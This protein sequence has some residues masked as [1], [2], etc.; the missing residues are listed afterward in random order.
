[1]RA[2]SRL[3]LGF[4][5]IIMC[6]LVLASCGGDDGLGDSS[7]VI[8]MDDDNTKAALDDGYTYRLPV[9]FHVLYNDADN[10]NQ[11]IPASRLQQLLSYVN[12]IYRGGIFGDSKTVGVTFVAA[13]YDE[14]GNKLSTPGVEYVKWTDSYP[15]NPSDFMSDNSGAYV[16]YLWDPNEYINVMLYNFQ[17]TADGNTI[18][19]ISHMP[20]AIQNDSTLA[21]LET[22][23]ARYI[24]KANLRYPHCVSINSLF[25]YLDEEGR[26]CE[27]DRYAA[28]DHKATYIN[29]SDIVVTLAH[30]LGHYLGLHHAFSES[31][32]IDADG[33]KSI[34]MTDGCL[35]SDYCDDT[36]SYNRIEYMDYIGYYMQHTPQ[37]K[38]QDV[39]ARDPCVG[40]QF[41]STNIMDYAYSLGYEIT[42]DQKD[43]MR[44][45]MYYCPMIPGPK[46]NGA[47][48]R[49]AG[50][51][52]G[53]K[54]DLHP[55]TVT[56][57]TTVHCDNTVS[58]MK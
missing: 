49:A 20:Y 11:H 51:T 48:T 25:A 31:M 38:L 33:S 30:E 15:I 56:C 45:V 54:L 41:V 44:W 24:S 29:P 8:D 12:M 46:R 21:G 7:E 43:R 35:D 14:K 39:I 16:S 40:Q 5:Y 2:I 34:T 47:N 32:S 18:L 55:V 10:L 52:S 28:A 53:I 1:M 50:Q 23:T 19:G 3:F 27:S 9:I 36:P 37:P 6:G 58:S 26:Y 42:Q 57:S 22:T 13:E 17:N 4:I